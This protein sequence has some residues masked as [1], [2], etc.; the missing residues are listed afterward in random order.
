MGKSIPNTFR[1]EGNTISITRSD[2]DFIAVASVKE[3]YLDEIRSFN[4]VLNNGYLYCHKIS[5][6][7]HI[8]IMRKWYGDKTYEAMKD[9]GFV[10]DHM[11]N[12]SFNCRIDNLCFLSSDENKA[13]GMTVD[14]LSANKTHIALT[15]YKDFDTQLIQIVVVFNY[16]AIAK[17]KNLTAPAVIDLAYLLYDR[18]YEMVLNDARTILYDY[19]KNGIFEPEMMHDIDYH[20][21]G[22][23]GFPGNKELYD[24][25]IE[26][27]H[28][29]TVFFITKKA[30]MLN[31]QKDDQRKFFYL[32]GNSQ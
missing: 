5:M 6:Y 19:H 21:E 14:K 17:I 20:I 22:A 2:W 8:Y 27:N 10:V 29:H 26:G 12:N 7:L 1:I 25:Y 15:L 32:R 13:K 24:K 9:E 31:W 23:Y 4:W 30:P 16:P 18:E 11:D 28:G 3:E